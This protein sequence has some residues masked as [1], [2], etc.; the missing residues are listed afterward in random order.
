MIYSIFYNENGL[1]ILLSGS[2]I[3]ISAFDFHAGDPS[4][5]TRSHYGTAAA[6]SAHHKRHFSCLHGLWT[7]AYSEV[8]HLR[9]QQ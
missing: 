6:A 5:S 4:D 7:T 2:G 9:S 3:G 8:L 1:G